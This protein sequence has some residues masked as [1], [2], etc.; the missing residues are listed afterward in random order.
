MVNERGRHSRAGFTLIE[1]IIALAVLSLIMGLGLFYGMENFRGETFRSEVDTM[2]GVLQK[3]RSR[4]MANIKQSQ[5]GVHYAG[6][7]DYTYTIFRG[8]DYAHATEKEVVEGGRAASISPSP[9]SDV[10]FTQLSGTTTGTFS[11]ILHEG[12]RTN[13]IQVNYEGTI[14]W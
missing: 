9:L 11:A 2:V 14:I 4:A 7:P 12:G 5:W 8:S 10:V 1:M 6:S 3:A 13:N